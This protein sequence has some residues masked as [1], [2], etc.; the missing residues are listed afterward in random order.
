M[1]VELEKKLRSMGV[2]DLRKEI[3]KTNVKGYSKLKKEDIIN[4]ML[5]Y[6]KRFMYLVGQEE[7]KAKLEKMNIL[8]QKPEV[9]KEEVK[10]PKEEP[11]KPEPK[12]E[13]SRLDKLQGDLK[14][15][16][17]ELSN[18]PTP[19]AA[20]TA[21]VA[22]NIDVIRTKLSSKIANLKFKIFNEKQ[23]QKDIDEKKK[24]KPKKSQVKKT[25]KK[26]APEKTALKK[27]VSDIIENIG[28]KKELSPSM[29]AMVDDINE[30]DNILGPPARYYFLNREDFQKGDLKLWKEKGED[31]FIRQENK[32]INN[33]SKDILSDLLPKIAKDKQKEFLQKFINIPSKYLVKAGQK[34]D[35][36]IFLKRINDMIN[37]IFN[38]FEETQKKKQVDKKPEEPSPPKKEA[39]KEEPAQKILKFDD[40]KK[41]INNTK[42]IKEIQNIQEIIA[43]S[44]LDI[45]KKDIQKIKKLIDNMKEKLFMLDDDE[46]FITPKEDIKESKILDLSKSVKS[47]LST[48]KKNNNIGEILQTFLNYLKSPSKRQF[49]N[50]L[51]I[52]IK[53]DIIENVR[54][55]MKLTDFFPT[56]KKCID[57]AKEYIKDSNN[58]IDPA[59]GLGY[60]LY[61]MSQINP[62]AKL[63]G[64]EYNLITSKVAQEI[65]KNSDIKI[66]RG[67]FFDIP[68]NNTYD[69]YF[70]NPPFTS[71]FSKKDKYYIKFL[72]Y[73]GILLDNSK[74]KTIYSQLL[75]PTTYLKEAG[76]KP[77]DIVNL[78]EVLIKAPLT[79]LK[80][81]FGELNFFNKLDININEFIKDYK[82][83]LSK[84]EK[85]DIKDVYFLI[86]DDLFTGECVYLSNCEFET[87]KFSIANLIFIRKK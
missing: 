13:I 1:S 39:K 47:Q 40:I 55:N 24:V 68:L 30:G 57:E 72:L 50:L 26:P 36:E 38:L 86:L 63:Q 75:F 65:F 41:L 15:L 83:E 6:P 42:N 14:V 16:E 7:K 60:P 44:K 73:L 21:E 70:L 33:K 8:K 23:K 5:K 76:Y 10:K 69:Y 45:Q 12:K 34:M 80:R 35:R 64:L 25:P 17:K 61:Y 27:V 56:P 84:G 48:S 22:R 87:T 49:D 77:G 67:D 74:V 3:S 62:K 59:C 66:E 53:G 20:K 46:K 28:K 31:D 52:G 4:L 19:R 71:S 81:Y 29:K 78:S 43:S 37:E 32:Y 79:E 11:K 51:K 18:M 58:I 85:Y 82:K 2:G 9:K 54:Q